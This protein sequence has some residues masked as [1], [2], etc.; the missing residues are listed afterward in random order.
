[1]F[2]KQPGKPKAAAKRKQKKTAADR[3]AQAV[4]FL[5]CIMAAAYVVIRIFNW[6]KFI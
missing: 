3:I 1:M 5:A 2:K 4:T 6:I